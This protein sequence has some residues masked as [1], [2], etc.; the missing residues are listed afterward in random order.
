M[1]IVSNSRRVLSRRG[2]ARLLAGAALVRVR[3]DAAPKGLNWHSEETP[4]LSFE[5]GYRADAQVLLFGIP[6]LHRSDVGRG[7]VLWRE[8]SA[9]DPGRLLAFTGY[10]LPERAAGLN[11]LGFIREMARTAPQGGSECIYFGLMTASPEESAAEARN[12]LHSKAKEQVYTAIDGRIGGGESETAI[13]HFLAPATI[14]G[15]HASELLDRARRALATVPRIAVPEPRHDFQQSFLQTLAGMLL[16]PD[17]AEA[18]YSYSGRIY[19]MRLSR[20]LDGKATAHFRERGMISRPARVVRVSGQIHREAGAKVAEFRLWIPDRGE[21]P[22]PLRI[23]YQPKSYL[24]L[25]FEADSG[26]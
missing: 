11:R 18:G 5:R 24:R 23:D 21:R 10:S 22:L 4:A 3:G 20:S 17:R 16:R 9:D 13:A 15:A 8:F 6:L 25:V 7:S 14:S 12:A 1:A 2:F 26:S 19:R